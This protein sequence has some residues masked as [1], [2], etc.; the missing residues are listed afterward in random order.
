MYVSHRGDHFQLVKSLNNATK[1]SYTEVSK[2]KYRI[3]KGKLILGVSANENVVIT[4]E[5]EGYWMIEF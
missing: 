1:W 4:D 3:T 2:N 5:W